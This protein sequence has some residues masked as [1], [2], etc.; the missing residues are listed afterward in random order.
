MGKRRLERSYTYYI[1]A[2][3][4]RG[5][6]RTIIT[7]V[8]EKDVLE[9]TEALDTTPGMDARAVEAIT[10]LYVLDASDVS[11]ESE[12]DENDEDETEDAEEPVF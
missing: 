1:Q 3:D 5:T 8:P 2:L 4:E 11:E 12:D 10:T 6:W 9:I 7:S